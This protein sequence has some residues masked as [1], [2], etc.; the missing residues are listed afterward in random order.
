[1]AQHTLV[2]KLLLQ[3]NKGARGRHKTKQ[4]GMKQIRQPSNCHVSLPAWSPHLPCWPA[5]FVLCPL[6]VLAFRSV[7]LWRPLTALTRQTR[8]GVCA[9][10]QST[11]YMMSFHLKQVNW[12]EMSYLDNVSNNTHNHENHYLTM[13]LY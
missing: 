2:V 8:Q 1:M 13:K 6:L 12:I 7:F 10:K 11:F 9:I 3:Q 4:A 5:W